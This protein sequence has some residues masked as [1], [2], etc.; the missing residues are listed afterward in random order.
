MKTTEA[1][2]RRGEMKKRKRKRERGR[3]RNTPLHAIS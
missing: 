1:G 3:R 2:G